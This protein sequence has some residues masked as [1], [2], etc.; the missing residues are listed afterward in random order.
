MFLFLFFK[1]KTAYY[2]RISD[3]SSDVCASE[4]QKLLPTVRADNS[5]V[6]ITGNPE[7]DGS[8]VDRRF[9]KDIAE[10]ANIV[11]LN[12]ADNPWFP[13]VLDGERKSDQRNLDPETYAWI[14]DGAYRETKSEERRG[15]T[16]CVSP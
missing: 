12:Y 5:E 9:R 13:A 14:W 6:W 10:D 4:L 2:M 8:P 16:E 15:G 3:W 1:Q 11:E 7:L